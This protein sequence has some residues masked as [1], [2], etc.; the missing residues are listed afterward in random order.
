MIR[1]CLVSVVE[2]KNCVR[3]PMTLSF[4]YRMRVHATIFTY[5]ADFPDIQT[6]IWNHAPNRIPI[7]ILT[8][9]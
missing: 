3:M 1:L 2:A 9:S 5:T 6:E 7:N 8:V 4:K